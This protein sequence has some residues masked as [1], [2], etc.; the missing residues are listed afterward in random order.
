MTE[1]EMLPDWAGRVQPPDAARPN[2]AGAARDHSRTPS[3]DEDV[4]PAPEPAPEV[5]SALGSGI[6]VVEGE[7]PEPPPQSSG[8]GVAPRRGNLQRLVL[9]A[10]LALIAG[11]VGGYIYLLIAG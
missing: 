5:E 4:S 1:L 7:V 6:A 3:T 2:D 8:A 11:G 10:V 9:L